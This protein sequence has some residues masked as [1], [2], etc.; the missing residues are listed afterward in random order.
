[1]RTLWLA[2]SLVVAA[3]A[4]SPW[5]ARAGDGR[6]IDERVGALEQRVAS[7]ESDVATLKEILLM[8]RLS[9]N[10]AAAIA[11]LRNLV[12]AQAQFEAAGVCDEDRD[13]VGEYGG[14]AELT[15]KVAGR[16]RAPL[17]P[18][19]LSAVFSTLNAN[20]EVERNGYVYRIWLA[21]KSGAAVGEPKTGFA[22]DGGH[23]ADLA[24]VVWCCYAWP[25]RA[26][27]TGGR[28]FFVNQEG[29]VLAAEGMPYQGVTPP[30]ADAAFTKDGTITGPSAANRRGV[31][32][33]V[34]SAVR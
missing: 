9:A 13:G 24:E 21:A 20:G 11:T 29:E 27:L 5:I 8:A 30:K 18:P 16:M 22:C 25:A 12:S 4:A 2:G 1:M 15:G 34:W 31:D 6:S 10:E 32:G 19:V 23:D 17:V 28:T 7:F 14:F 26:G 33:A 3:V